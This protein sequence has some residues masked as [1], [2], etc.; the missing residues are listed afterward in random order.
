[1]KKSSK[2]ES[3]QS[4]MSKNRQRKLRRRVKKFIIELS[5]FQNEVLLTN[6]IK[7]DA[8]SI[9]AI[10]NSFENFVNNIIKSLEK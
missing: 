6:I 2:N 10:I 5:D 7:D 3:A 9:Y 4:K 8:N 1:M